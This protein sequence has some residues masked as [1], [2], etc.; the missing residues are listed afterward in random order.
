MGLS[1]SC[2][3]VTTL[4]GEVTESSVHLRS[5]LLIYTRSLF[6]LELACKIFAID[7]PSG[8]SFCIDGAVVSSQHM[9][10]HRGNRVQ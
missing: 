7:P 6:R 9:S 3:E 10:R 2:E 1:S 8:D 5:A 4:N